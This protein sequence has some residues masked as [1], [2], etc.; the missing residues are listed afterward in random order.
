[1]HTHSVGWEP[2]AHYQADYWNI[3]MNQPYT[4]VAN[5]TLT[6]TRGNQGLDMLP[7]TRKI[8]IQYGTLAIT[9]QRISCLTFGTTQVISIKPLNIATRASFP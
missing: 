7:K 1:M 3:A 5:D 4:F 9:M 8:L 2:L 6:A